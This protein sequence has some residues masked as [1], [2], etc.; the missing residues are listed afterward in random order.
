MTQLLEALYRGDEERVDALLAG[1][2]EL[3]V[4][5]AAALGRTDR[6]PELLEAEPGLANAYGDDGFQPLG[7]ACFF[8]HVEAARVLLERGADPNTLSRNEHV[9]TNALHAAAASENKGPEVRYELCKLLLEHG[10]DASIPQGDSEF[11]A[12]D[13]AQMNGDKDLE[14]LL[15]ASARS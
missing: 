12:I 13:A 11:R 6:L 10:A 9:K 2:P 3:N 5:E 8:G 14:R 15:D 4:F 7:L 1:E